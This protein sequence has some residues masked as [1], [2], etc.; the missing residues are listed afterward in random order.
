MQS[1]T[2]GS[3]ED[4][5][6]DT[7]YVISFEDFTKEEDYAKPG[8]RSETCKE[9]PAWMKIKS[10]VNKYADFKNEFYINKFYN[11]YLLKVYIFFP[12]IIF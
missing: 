7:Y 9:H 10:V 6:G 11:A 8:F 2:R 1:T 3:W 5:L 4:N 12:L